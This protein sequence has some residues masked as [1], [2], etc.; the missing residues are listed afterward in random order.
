MQRHFIEPSLQSITEELTSALTTSLNTRIQRMLFLLILFLVVLLMGYVA[1]WMPLVNE[2]NEQINK[3]KLMLM[4]VPID[5]LMRM[6]GIA[7]I[8]EGSAAGQDLIENSGL[9]ASASM[10]LG[11]EHQKNSSRSISGSSN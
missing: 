7:K 5:I 10:A 8:L 1:A 6:R 4:I 3:T 9:A 11:K 2:L